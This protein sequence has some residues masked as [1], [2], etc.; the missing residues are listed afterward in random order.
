LSL[1][2]I[3][4]TSTPP[5]EIPDLIVTALLEYLNLFIRFCVSNVCTWI[6]HW[7][8]MRILNKHS[9]RLT[10]LL[11]QIAFIL[12]GMHLPKGWRQVFIYQ[13]KHKCPCITNMF[14]FKKQTNPIAFLLSY[15]SVKQ[16][17]YVHMYALYKSTWWCCR[18]V[19][20]FLPLV[21][22]MQFVLTD[23]TWTTWIFSIYHY[24]S[25]AKRVSKCLFRN[26]Q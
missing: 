15:P 26:F 6:L 12:I 1:F 25:H 23:M 17:R 9:G 5:S 14:Y 21:C 7:H 10:N 19:F 24:Q 8:C 13:A 18:W 2:N 11:G 22:T 20:T 4:P 16:G 3:V